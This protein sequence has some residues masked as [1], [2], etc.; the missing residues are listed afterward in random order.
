MLATLLAMVTAFS[1]IVPTI[2]LASDAAASKT[3]NFDSDAAGA[4]PTGF[5]FARTGS[6][7][8]GR[9]V[10]RADP[11]APSGGNI[12]AQLDT[13]DTDYRFPLAVTTDQFPADLSLT[14]KC[15]A[16]SGSV[17]QACGLVFRYLDADN[18]YVV[19]ANALEDN[20][21]L[22]YVKGG[23]R[24]QFAS[25]SGKVANGVWH[26]LRVDAKANEFQVFWDGADVLQGRD[27]TFKSGGHVGVWTK[28]DSVTYFD[29]LAVAPLR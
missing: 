27:G 12:L 23:K 3:W 25:W 10:V 2:A 13:D 19:R 5:M 14:V 29:D 22:Y 26:Q 21:R 17:D 15:K 28:A 1:A 24:K 20:V 8:E 4:L 18:Y 16:V 6:G 7:R 11:S 9:W